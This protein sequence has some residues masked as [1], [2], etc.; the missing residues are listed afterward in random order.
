MF[1]L[2]YDMN[3]GRMDAADRLTLGYRRPWESWGRRVPIFE[4][5]EQ[6]PGLDKPA[7]GKEGL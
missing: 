3:S 5:P 2:G 4:K 1:I 6:L 7:S